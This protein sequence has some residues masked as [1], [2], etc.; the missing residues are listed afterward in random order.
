MYKKQNSTTHLYATLCVP[1][2]TCHTRVL[3]V[4]STTAVDLLLVHIFD[5]IVY[6][7]LLV[8][9]LFRLPF[10]KRSLWVFLC[11]HR[12]TN[13]I[14]KQA[15]GNF[16]LPCL[17]FPCR[18]NTVYFIE[19]LHVSFV[20]LGQ[21]NLAKSEGI[22][23]PVSHKNHHWHSCA[24]T[25][26]HLTHTTNRNGT[27]TTDDHRFGLRNQWMVSRE[28]GHVAGAMFLPQSQT[29]TPGHPLQISTHSSV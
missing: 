5:K 15:D 18:K 26:A 7:L 27:N 17:C 24:T 6:L 8:Q 22:L 9:I 16:S 12:C 29:E 25:T 14:D 20:L 21:S 1:R 11:N 2:A 28:G 4:L 23:L 10:F 19:P 13:R 3:P